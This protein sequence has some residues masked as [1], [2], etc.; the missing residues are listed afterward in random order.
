[1]PA[2]TT[3]KIIS[4]NS[5]SRPAKRAIS[6]WGVSDQ[7]GAIWLF[8]SIH[9]LL[10]H[11]SWRMPL[12]DATLA[13]ADQVVFGID[14]GPT[15]IAEMG[16]QAFVQGIYVD[17]TLLTDVITERR[18][19]QFAASFSL[20]MG[21]I[22]AMPPWMAANTISVA[23]LTPMGYHA[24]GSSSC[25]NQKSR[26]NGRVIWRPANSNWRCWPAPGTTSKWPC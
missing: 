1:M 11:V 16:D 17:D 13:T 25:C 20:L 21:L 8:G 3:P 10:E 7:N 2:S 24:Q 15:A 6:V 23:A 9:V 22:L 5:G 12:F 18:L 26:H 14:I 4:S 19:P